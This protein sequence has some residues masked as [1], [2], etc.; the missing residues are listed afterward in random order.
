[1][2]TLLRVQQACEAPIKGVVCVK[3]AVC[4]YKISEGPFRHWAMFAPPKGRTTASSAV[5]T[6]LVCAQVPVVYFLMHAHCV[7]CVCS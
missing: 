7:R 4:D 5:A 2:L 1:M 3:E 6:R